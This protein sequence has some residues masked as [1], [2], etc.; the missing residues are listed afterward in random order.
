MKSG[1]IVLRLDQVLMTDFFAESFITLTLPWRRKSMYGPFFIERP[2]YFGYFLRLLTIKRFEYFL[3]VRV[4][5]PLAYKPV[6]E[7][8]CP[9]EARPS[10]PPIG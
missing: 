8:G 5:L 9:P 7:R 1:E 2:I 3:G 4:F 10:P 6:R